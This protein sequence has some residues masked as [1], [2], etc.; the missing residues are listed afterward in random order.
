VRTEQVLLNLLRNA[1]EA[2]P[3]EGLPS[4]R[5]RGDESEVWIEVRDRGP[6]IDPQAMDRLFEPFFTT[7]SQG[8]GL[9]L[10]LAV[11][12]MILRDMGGE[13]TARNEPGGGASFTITLPRAT[14]AQSLTQAA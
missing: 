14:A 9:G 2:Q 3:S 13:L 11:S 12:V 10:G 5:V 1:L 7:K 8:H 6:G 4:V